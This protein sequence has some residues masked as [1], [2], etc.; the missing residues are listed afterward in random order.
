ML[1]QVL[2]QLASFSTN[3]VN[4]NLIEHGD[5]GAKLILTPIQ[6]IAKFVAR[7]FDRMDNHILK[8]TYPDSFPKFTSRDANPKYQLTNMIANMANGAAVSISG[9]KSKPDASPPR[10]SCSREDKQKAKTQAGCWWVEG[11]Y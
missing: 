10:H 11:L 6:N 3:A 1:H 8:G 5:N 4:N 7:F 2:A 9:V